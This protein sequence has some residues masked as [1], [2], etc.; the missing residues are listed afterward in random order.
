MWLVVGLGNP[1][2]RYVDTPHNVGFMVLDRLAV[3]AKISAWRSDDAALTAE[4]V[5]G[6]RRVKLVE[7]Q[8]FMNRSGPV[9]ARLLGETPLAEL[10]VVLDDAALERGRIRVRRGGSDGGHRGLASVIEAVGGTAFPRV[11]LGVGSAASG[12]LAE[13]VLSPWSTD[14]IVLVRALIERATDAVACVLAEGVEVAMNR[15]NA[16]GAEGDSEP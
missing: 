11:R 5:V 9:V 4:V 2:P 14:D 6:G 8:A 10:L 13:H 1:G 7:P 12:E 15:F 3:L 16:A